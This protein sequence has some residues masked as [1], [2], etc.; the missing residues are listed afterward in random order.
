[1]FYHP[2]F[3]V[4]ELELEGVDLGLCASAS[5]F[6][7]STPPVIIW[8]LPLY[9]SKLY[10]VRRD[11]LLPPTPTHPASQ[12]GTS[13]SVSFPRIPCLPNLFFKGH[14]FN[15]DIYMLKNIRERHTPVKLLSPVLKDG[16]LVSVNWVVGIFQPPAPTIWMSWRQ[17]QY[18]PFLDRVAHLPPGLNR[19]LEQFCY[20]SISNICEVAPL[21]SVN[22]SGCFPAQTLQA[23]APLQIHI[24]L[25]GT[26]KRKEL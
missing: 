2:C 5:V 10:C 1:M 3:E 26:R 16:G 4:G 19:S 18:I 13:Q 20:S 17:L 25:K 15:L 24:L 8:G 7:W 9:M 21:K 14:S 22:K 23:E 12:Q 6:I 11:F